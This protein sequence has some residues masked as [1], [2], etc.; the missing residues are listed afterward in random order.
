MFSIAAEMIYR[1]ISLQKHPYI[2]RYD[3]DKAEV[4]ARW[5]FEKVEE[6]NRQKLAKKT[7]SA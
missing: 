6:I 5:V 7:S 1:K 4:I 2:E 3:D